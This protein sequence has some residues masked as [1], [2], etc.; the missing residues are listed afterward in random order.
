MASKK[1]LRWI[2]LLCVFSLGLWPVA[3]TAQTVAPA[4]KIHSSLTEPTTGIGGLPGLLI[5]MYFTVH[6]KTGAVV[7]N[8]EL[9]SAQIAL[10]D[11]SRYEG[12]LV[13][14]GKTWEIAYVMDASGNMGSWQAYYDYD[15]V[16]KAAIPSLAVGPKGANYS[17]VKYTEKSEVV[18][19]SGDAGKAADA[20]KALRATAGA[21]SCMRDALFDTIDNV[22]AATQNSR[23]A[24]VLFAAS[25]DDCSQHTDAQVIAEAKKNGVEIM[26]VGLSGY[27]LDEKVLQSYA[28]G[29]GGAFAA[30]VKDEQ[31][32]AF[33]E[34][35]VTLTNEGLVQATLY[36]SA[37]DH[38]AQLQVTLKN[39]GQVLVSEVVAFTSDTNY[40]RPPSVALLGE[41][42]STH[43]SI[44]LNVGVTNPEAIAKLQILVASVKTGQVIIENSPQVVDASRP[45]ELPADNLVADEEYNV[46]IKAQN[47]AGTFLPDV[48][49]KFKY[50]PPTGSIQMSL[51]RLPTITKPQF[52]F[53]VDSQNL[54]DVAVKYRV[55]LADEKLDNVIP[56]TEQLI[57][58]AGTIQIPT[59]KLSAGKYRVF[60]EARDSKDKV[61]AST[62]FATIEYVP[63]SFTDKIAL[64]LRD[65]A[66]N[67][68]LL[69][70]LMVVALGLLM[71]V[72][73]LVAPRSLG[74]G[75]RVDLVIQESSRKA[76]ASAPPPAD[77][78]PR[79]RQ[80]APP[81][82][83]A[84][85]PP[86]RH[87]HEPSP[88]MLM[89]QMPVAPQVRPGAPQRARLVVHHLPVGV[90]V[91]PAVELNKS[92][93]TLGRVNGDLTVA[94]ARVSRRHAVITQ[95]QG[96]YYIQDA[97]SANGT[98]VNGMRLEADRKV[99]LASG[100][101][102][103]L[104]PEILLKFELF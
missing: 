40:A 28:T 51:T 23:R 2:L 96:T 59:D 55:W 16:R 4:V 25:R 33:R 9:T 20:I 104:G 76:R 50:A 84:A 44:M 65:L 43:K 71:V 60:L 85:P 89:P 42:Q 11:G 58:P 98:L 34:M 54:E 47:T 75:R 79:S 62:V 72:L 82:R 63:P 48:S 37:G 86:A 57:V 46:V 92:P 3:A 93:F 10:E 22:L 41:V 94:D 35:L 27:P 73:F 80:A 31:P 45:I 26:V 61:V 64:Q 8:V 90:Q 17:V 21:H 36:P 97:A 29:T 56:D 1:Y 70:L 30:A 38:Q 39:G 32:F 53:N 87:Q 15:A 101:I 24:I 52:S 100:A 67:A 69:S 74:R 7:E 66:G 77:P 13:D 88:T 78:A 19:K 103:G 99:P 6:D 81:P 68:A 95:E 12:A 5:G 102:I 18:F 91:P 49:G 83:A 14:P